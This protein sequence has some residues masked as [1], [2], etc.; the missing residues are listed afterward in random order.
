MH[1]S[2]DYMSSDLNNAIVVPAERNV[3]ADTKID[4]VMP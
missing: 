2:G 4:L 1:K 3:I